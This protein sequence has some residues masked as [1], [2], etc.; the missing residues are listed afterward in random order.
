M[1]R[2]ILADL[3]RAWPGALAIALII[4]FATALGITVTLQER[5]LRL[6]SARAADAFD[7]VIGAPASETQLVLSSVFLQ[8]APL[9]LMPG[10]VMG[11]LAA[12]P[13]VAW[14]APIGFGDAHEGWPVVGTTGALIDGLGGIAKGQGFARLGDAVVGARVP[15]A[16]G[17]TFH[18][19]HAELA[20]EG[21][22]HQGTTYTVRGVLS[23]TGSPWDRAILVP[24]EAV[25]QSHGMEAGHDKEGDARHHE[26]ALDADQPVNPAAVAAPNAPGVP[27]IVVRGHTIAD[28]YNLRQ[29]YRGDR[30]VA[31]FPAEVLTRL[32][33][34]LGDARSV[35]SA[36]A[37]AAQA[38]VAAAVLLVALLHV[39]Q[40]QRQIGALRAF[41]ASRG[42]IFLIVWGEVALIAAAGVAAGIGL[43]WL[44]A[45]LISARIEAASGVAMPVEFAAS[46][47]GLVL[48]LL[49][50]AGACALIPAAIAYR[51]SPAAALRG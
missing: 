17:D 15:M 42:V 14:A 45:R 5:A 39:T 13:R 16:P 27:A 37:I 50:A 25:W 31:V 3:R 20:A 10:A 47:L 4:A 6:G 2:F 44:A 33:G 41:G 29:H 43:G 22:V 51:Q 18:P 46:D 36:V 24:I 11:E 9:P 48:G 26:G 28:A 23:P 30:S 19:V 12:D 40:R 49:A 35:L 7:L 21:E 1:L 34:T 38:L 32:Y 8:P